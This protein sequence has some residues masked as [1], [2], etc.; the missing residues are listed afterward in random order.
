MM[1]QTQKKIFEWPLLFLI[2]VLIQAIEI[3][4]LDLPLGLSTLHFI[5]VLSIYIALTRSWGQILLLSF[6]LGI[7]GSPAIGYPAAIYISVLAWTALTTKAVVSA[8]ALE[9][10]RP[11]VGLTAA[12]HIFSRL[13]TWAL[14]KNIGSALPFSTMFQWMIGSTLTTSFLAWVLFPYFVAWDEYFEHEADEARELNPNV[15]R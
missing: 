4:L 12:S 9:G 1:T 10:R 7:L 13:L 11:F 8:L 5:P 14:L 6:V 15:L 3:S 2:L